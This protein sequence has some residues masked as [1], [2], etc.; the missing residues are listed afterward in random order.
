MKRIALA[1]SLALLCSPAFA[2]DR[3]T[4]AQ[5][6]WYGTLSGNWLVPRDYDGDNRE[7][8]TY[9]GYGIYGAL[10]YR[11]DQSWRTEAEMGYG[12]VENDRI[13]VGNFSSKV[14]GDINYYSATVALYYDMPKVYSLTPYIGAGAGIVH[15]QNERN[16]VTVGGVNFPPGADSTDLTAFGEIGVSYRL[17]DSLELIPGYRYQWINDG[18]DGF[19]DSGI[20]IA[21]IGLRY[22][23][24]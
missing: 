1:F 7:W 5:P 3:S 4:D 17:S 12:T 18:R 11:L 15:Q 16:A 23:F 6:R 20:H 24:N 19:D 22:W 9:N 13:S 14:D 10:G 2:Q 8:K 21:H